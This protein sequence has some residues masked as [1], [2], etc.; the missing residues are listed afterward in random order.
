M[1]NISGEEL[2]QRLLASHSQDIICKIR[3]ANRKGLNH[4]AMEPLVIAYFI[5]AKAELIEALPR[6][7]TSEP[8]LIEKMFPVFNCTIKDI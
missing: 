8:D 1:K 5:R 6:E 7:W 2:A 4:Q 3:L